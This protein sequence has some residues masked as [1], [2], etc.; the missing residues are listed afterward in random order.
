MT[1]ARWLGLTAPL[2]FLGGL[3]VVGCFDSS[4]ALLPTGAECG[5]LTV[6]DAEAC[7]G[8]VCLG[9]TPNVQNMSGFCSATCQ[10]DADCS[11]HEFCQ[12]STEGNF[13]FRAC[14]TDADCY[15][16]FVCR[17]FALGGQHRFCLVDP[18]Q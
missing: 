3:L 9:I 14:V 12:S 17:L 8:G 2:L 5:G 10:V 7:E 11:P 16:A 6:E 1:L 18:T 4:A 15:D 13:C